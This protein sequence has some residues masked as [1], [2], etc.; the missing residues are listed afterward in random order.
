MST[1]PTPASNPDGTDPN[2][3]DG[4]NIRRHRPRGCRGSGKLKRER[5]R[6]LAAL[7]VGSLTPETLTTAQ[8][9]VLASVLTNVKKTP[10]AGGDSATSNINSS[11]NSNQSST[12]NHVTHILQQHQLHLEKVAMQQQQQQQ[13][14]SHASSQHLQMMQQQVQQSHFLQPNT[15]T[16][17]ISSR[18]SMN[19]NIYYSNPASSSS[20]KPVLDHSSPSKINQSSVSFSNPYTNR[21][22]TNSVA[23][24]PHHNLTLVSNTS[25]NNQLNNHLYAS[26]SPNLVHVTPNHNSSGHRLVN[27]PSQNVHSFRAVAPT[28]AHAPHYSHNNNMNNTN[29]SFM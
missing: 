10:P 9:Q 24:T 29:N 8:A 28:H 5:E 20:V 4:A 15:M 6:L 18:M 16:G 13:Q 17:Q 23:Y 7:A 19:S 1:S 22:V 3:A 21:Q 26:F 11:S 2:N 14:Q 25:V 27:V 12:I